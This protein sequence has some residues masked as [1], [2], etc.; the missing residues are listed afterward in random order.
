MSCAAVTSEELEN[1]L[2]RYYKA[3][4]NPNYSYFNMLAQVNGW[5]NSDD[6]SLSGVVVKVCDGLKLNNLY[7]DSFATDLFRL[8]DKSGVMVKNF[9]G[10]C[11]VWDSQ[12]VIIQSSDGECAKLANGEWDVKIKGGARVKGISMCVVNPT[13]IIGGSTCK[14]RIEGSDYW[15]DLDSRFYDAKFS[16]DKDCPMACVSMVEDML[17]HIS[18]DFETDNYIEYVEPEG[19]IATMEEEYGEESYVEEK[20]I[21]GKR[22]ALDGICWCKYNDVLRGRWD[23]IGYDCDCG[24]IRK[25]TWWMQIAD[26]RYEGEVKCSATDSSHMDE[27]DPVP[28]DEKGDYC[29]CKTDGSSWRFATGFDNDLCN[30]LCD[31]Y[32][33]GRA[34]PDYKSIDK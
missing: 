7:C 15:R 24:D 8:V 30:G 26:K 28:V 12:K 32:C 1:L 4:N 3:N 20:Q 29:W 6:N 33:L 10:E 11:E 25:G 19:E 2:Q 17:G 23:D 18:S 14:C 5:L 21:Y 9:K 31:S 13:G 34:L 27:V 22:Y 16:C